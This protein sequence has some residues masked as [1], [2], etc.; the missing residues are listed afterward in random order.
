MPVFLTFF[1]TRL[2]FGRGGMQSS[3]CTRHHQ[4]SACPC[5][6]ALQHTDFQYSLH[7]KK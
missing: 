6:S 4:T 7:W 5:D 2:E 3:S 1:N